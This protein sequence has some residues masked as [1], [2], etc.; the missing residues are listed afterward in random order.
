MT[1]IIGVTLQSIFGYTI[2]SIILRFSY[3]SR[4]IEK[5]TSVKAVMLVGLMCGAGY[6]IGLITE[7]DTHDNTSYIISLLLDIIILTIIFYSDVKNIIKNWNNKESVRV[8][9][10]IPLEELVEVVYLKKIYKKIHYKIHYNAITDPVQY[11]IKIT[12]IAFLT[13]CFLE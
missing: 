11:A 7:Q 12:I 5:I 6:S 3:G 2:L 13:G 9:I 4:L 8:P 10:K 1:A